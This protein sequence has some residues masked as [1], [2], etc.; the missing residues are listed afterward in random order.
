[1]DV[2]TDLLYTPLETEDKIILDLGDV[3]GDTSPAAPVPLL[4]LDVPCGAGGISLGMKEAFC[5]TEPRMDDWHELRRRTRPKYDETKATFIG[6]DFDRNC[7]QTYQINRVGQAIRADMAH[8]PFRDGIVF[9]FIVGGPPCQG[10][11]TINTKARTKK[12]AD[13]TYE[14]P[15]NNL[16]YIFADI[17]KIYQPAY[18]MFEN[19]PGIRSWDKGEIFKHLHWLF[20]KA[21]Y[22]YEWR[23]T[24]Y[25]HY[26]IP[27]SRNR[28]IILGWMPGMP[29]WIFPEPT[30]YCPTWKEK[31]YCMECG[32]YMIRDLVRNY[33]RNHPKQTRQ[34]QL[35]NFAG[36]AAG[37]SQ[38]Y[39]LS[40]GKQGR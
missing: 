5:R 28:V 18:F 39:P 2:P 34:T 11:S 1:M 38:S 14:D 25:V 40:K 22:H 6:V 33:T 31:G 29:R 26:G 10:F 15:R 13:S 7:C 32:G 27:Q 30:N 16:S 37:V 35:P 24:N 8:L 19:V 4:I 9:D 3:E 23:L 20:H 36:T 12:R 17:V 21:G